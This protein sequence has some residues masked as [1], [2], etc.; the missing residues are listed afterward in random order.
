[1]GSEVSTC[2][3]VYHFGI[4]LL[5]MFT[6]KSP[7]D[8]LFNDGLNLHNF[9]R[10]ALPEHVEEITDSLLEGA[11]TTVDEACNQTIKRQQRIKESLILIFEI[12]IGYSTESP[13]NRKDISDVVSELHSIR[14]NLPG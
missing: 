4:L 13:T 7:T 3:D 8:P 1:M 12:G 2:G 10:M 5:E 9:V 11:F 6:R 14:N